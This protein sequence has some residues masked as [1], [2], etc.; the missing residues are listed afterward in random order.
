MYKVYLSVFYVTV[1]YDIFQIVFELID[2]EILNR[3]KYH[4]IEKVDFF[5]RCNPFQTI[6][7]DIGT[8]TQFER[9]VYDYLKNP[10]NK[11]F[12]V[13]L[14]KYIDDLNELTQ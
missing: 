13:N 5:E 4:G 2:G 6:S 14:F 7:P 3:R 12:E 1:T 10:T 9:R 11:E 8:K